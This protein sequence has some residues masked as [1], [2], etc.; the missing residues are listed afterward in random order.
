MLP[1]L[2]ITT[3]LTI[4]LL[5]LPTYP[6]SCAITVSSISYDLSPLNGLRQVARRIPTPP[7]ESETVVRMDLC[8]DEG[9]QPEPEG[10]PDQDEVSK[11]SNSRYG[12]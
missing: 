5:A 9:V 6:F 10:Y 2:S 1:S 8:S 7:T 4:V 12:S 11:R 3:L